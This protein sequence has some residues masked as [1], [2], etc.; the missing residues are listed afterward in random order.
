MDLVKFYCNIKIEYKPKGKKYTIPILFI[1]SFIL[2][3]GILN[4]YLNFTE[5]YTL[6]TEIAIVAIMMCYYLSLL[7]KQ[8]RPENKNVASLL[9]DY[10]ERTIKKVCFI[11]RNRIPKRGYHCDTC[12]VCIEQYDHHCTWICNCVGKNNIARFII[13]IVM[14]VIVL[15]FVG[16]MAVLSTLALL[17]DDHDKFHEIFTFRYLPT[18][19]LEKFSMIGCFLVNEVTS[20]FFFPVAMLCLVQIRNLLANKTTFE[21]MRAPSDESQLIKSK[22]NKAGKLSLRNCRVMCTD[23]KASFSTSRASFS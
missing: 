3:L 4:F 23:T 19:D 13:F 14:L 20:V 2:N 6:Y 5:D 18:T 21:K 16:I 1:V 11:C 17:Y 8:H 9:E 12:G 22:I 7:K 10:S 15:A